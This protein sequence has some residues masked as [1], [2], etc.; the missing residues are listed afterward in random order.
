MKKIYLLKLILIT[1]LF[2]STSFTQT[3]KEFIKELDRVVEKVQE[4]F[5]VPGVS[6]AIVKDS[7]VYYTRG[8]GTT[9]IE[10]GTNV[11]E[12]TVFGI[13]S[14]TKAFTSAGIAIL[15]DE[16]LINWT[17]KVI[18]YIPDFEMYDPY[19]TR[20]FTIKD[21]LTHQSGLTGG[22]GDLMLWPSSDFSRT[23]IIKKMKHFKPKHSFRT[24]FG[25][26]N[27]LY[28]VAGEVIK[29]VTGRSWEEFTKEKILNVLEMNNSYM[30]VKELENVSNLAKPHIKHMDKINS[31]KIENTDVTGPAATIYSTA[32]DI[33]KWMLTHLN[34]G[35]SPLNKKKV[36]SPRRSYEMWTPVTVFGGKRNGTFPSTFSGY[37]LGWGISDYNGNRIISHTGGLPGMVSKVTLVPEIGLGVAV[38]TNQQS[39]AA[40]NAISYFVLEHFLNKNHEDH[41]ET[42]N[43]KNNMRLEKVNKNLN[44]IFK[45]RNK[46]SKPSLPLF[47]YSGVY[48]DNWYGEVNLQLIDEK[49]ILTFPRSEGLS[50]ELTHFQYDTFTVKWKNRIIDAD[51]YVYFSLDEKGNIERMRMKPISPLTD[52]SY[53]F[54]DLD[55]S[56]K[57]KSELN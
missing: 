18:D 28:I 19:V 5:D 2:L 15:V 14:N 48:K 7:T 30:G 37:G 20:E 4:V 41:I 39:G 1:F 53:D 27:I 13:A 26:S 54:Q 10:E 22:Y 3:K 16:G 23:E 36:F 25:Y 24:R 8:F 11:D 45:S 29:S 52:F 46:D 35:T 57:K 50:G 6:I 55:F 47:K 43:S 32:N 42:Y 40:F 49:L 21:L 12:N 17:D 51:C 31:I 33:S 34:K 9:K 44:N 38:F 56:P